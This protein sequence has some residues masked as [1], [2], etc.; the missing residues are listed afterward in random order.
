M[1]P[2]SKTE[3]RNTVSNSAGTNEMFDTIRF[4]IDQ[5]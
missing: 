3:V 4:N 5:L 2:I 1:P